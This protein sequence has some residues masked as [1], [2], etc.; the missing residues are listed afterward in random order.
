M[1]VAL[2]DELLRVAIITVPLLHRLEQ[3]LYPLEELNRES[4]AAADGL[5][6]EGKDLPVLKG[7][8]SRHRVNAVRL[9]DLFCVLGKS[10]LVEDRHFGVQLAHQRIYLRKLLTV[11]AIFLRK[12]QQDLVVLL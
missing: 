12:V 5:V 10:E 11:L 3:P 7:K 6:T 2:H 9:N 4:V 1:V 8:Y